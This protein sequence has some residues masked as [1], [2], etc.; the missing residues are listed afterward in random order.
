M[1]FQLLYVVRNK[2]FYFRA[3]T[4]KVTSFEKARFVSSKIVSDFAFKTHSVLPTA[5]KAYCK[6]LHTKSRLK[7]FAVLSQQS[8]FRIRFHTIFAAI[9]W[10]VSQSGA[11]NPVSLRIT[12]RSRAEL[13][14]HRPFFS[15][16]WCKW[17][18]RTRH[19]AFQ[20]LLQSSPE[21]AETTRNYQNRFLL[22]LIIFGKLTYLLDTGVNSFLT[23]L[24]STDQTQ[25]FTRITSRR[26]DFIHSR[27]EIKEI[28]DPEKHTFSIE[29]EHRST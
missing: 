23:E 19:T 10:R 17:T 6:V 29:S 20:K 4:W 9:L 21:R 18:T 13:A 12:H 11:L 1:R 27:S 3:P 26:A 2:H 25:K 7:Y 8:L 28:H 15:A 24:F 16:P 22:W 14:F 5:S